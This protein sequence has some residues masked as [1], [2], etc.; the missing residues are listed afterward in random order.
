M[1]EYAR[2]VGYSQG[3]VEMQYQ[4]GDLSEDKY[5]QYTSAYTKYQEEKSLD[6]F[7]ELAKI[8]NDILEQ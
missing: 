3:V 7:H 4:L 5:A 8:I 6:N 2:K 1:A